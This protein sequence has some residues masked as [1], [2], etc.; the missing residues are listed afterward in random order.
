[1]FGV[2]LYSHQVVTIGCFKGLDDT[3]RRMSGDLSIRCELLDGL[4]MHRIAADMRGCK[5]AASRESGRIVSVWVS[6]VQARVRLFAR[7]SMDVS[8]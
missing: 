2:A 4:M 6:S 5:I 3:V 1:M 7:W 8:S